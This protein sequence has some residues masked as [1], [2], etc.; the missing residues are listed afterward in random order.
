[1]EN[2]ANEI[3]LWPNDFYRIKRYFS[4]IQTIPSSILPNYQ[5]YLTSTSIINLTSFVGKCLFVLIK[6]LRERI[7]FEPEEVKVTLIAREKTTPCDQGRARTVREVPTCMISL[8]NLNL[9]AQTIDSVPYSVD[10]N[11]RA[12][13]NFCSKNEDFIG[14]SD[15]L[16]KFR[17]RTNS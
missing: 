11:K 7:A 3:F 13:N 16:F 2:D 1:M 5:F 9:F 12:R 6:C 8:G 17:V 4:T 14:F 15:F 10:I